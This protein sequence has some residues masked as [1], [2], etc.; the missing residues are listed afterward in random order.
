MVVRVEAGLRFC[1]SCSGEI[2]FRVTLLSKDRVAFVS[3]RVHGEAFSE[4]DELTGKSLRFTLHP[5]ENNTAL[6]ITSLYA[7]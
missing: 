6:L 2:R 1:C 3:I 7:C 4:L 5:F